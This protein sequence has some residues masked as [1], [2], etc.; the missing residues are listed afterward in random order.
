[1]AYKLGVNIKDKRT[2]DRIRSLEANH[3][4][5]ASMRYLYEHALDLIQNYFGRYL[6]PFE[7]HPGKDSNG[8]HS[9]WRITPQGR[10][11]KGTIII[12]KI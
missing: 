9:Y 7:I 12:D 2:N 3:R 1:M 4:S 11:E 6:K 5:E 8:N 10:K